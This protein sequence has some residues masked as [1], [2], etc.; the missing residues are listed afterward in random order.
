[1][2]TLAFKDGVLASDSRATLGSGLIITDK[3]KKVY[4]LRKK[5]GHKFLIY[6]ERVLAV[7]FCGSAS[8]IA[9]YIYH[10]LNGELDTLRLGGLS[11]DDMGGIAITKDSA[12]RFSSVAPNFVRYSLDDPLADGSGLP[13]ALSAMHLGFSAEGAVEHAKTL[14]SG[15][16]GAVQSVAV[17][18]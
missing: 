13:Y 6:G 18:E 3:A 1:M 16:G 11:H 14:D 5:K 7:A 10:A 9:G 15:S 8:L 2:T 17:F 4:D 12:Y